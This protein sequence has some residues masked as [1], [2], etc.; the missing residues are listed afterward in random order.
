MKKKIFLLILLA[1]FFFISGVVLHSKN[2]SQYIKFKHSAKSV[3][4]K[5]QLQN[6]SKAA[7]RSCN[8]R[9][10]STIPRN[11]HLVV[12]HLYKHPSVNN[13]NLLGKLPE[14]IYKNRLNIKSVIFTGDIFYIPSLE[15]WNQLKATF[16][17]LDIQYFIAPGN[18]DVGI[19]NGPARD[20]FKLAFKSEYPFLWKEKD[21]IFLIEDSTINSWHLS[22]KSLDLIN[23]NKSNNSVLHIF[24]HNIILDELYP[25]ANSNI[26]KPEKITSVTNILDGLEDSFREVRIISGDTGAFEFLPTTA[27]YTYK[28]IFS[29]TNGL[30]PR[31]SNEVL[32]IKNNEIF[33]FLF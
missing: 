32:I 33:S 30:G 12:G 1:L 6:L 17:E 4:K 28:N 19:N 3:V 23:K 25:Y 14:L 31:E 9:Q 27:C 11:S 16:E 15:K 2:P 5:I 24:T 18:H 7:S 20:L 10:I 21:S 22:Q 8:I 29:I 26:G 13:K